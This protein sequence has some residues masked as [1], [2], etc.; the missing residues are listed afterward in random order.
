[1]A[2]SLVAEQ[3]RQEK[4]VNDAIVKKGQDEMQYLFDNHIL[5][6][7]QYY[8]IASKYGYG[9]PDVYAALKASIGTYINVR[10]GGSSGSSG[11][12]GRSGGS[13]RSGGASGAN[14]TVLKSLFGTAGIES[15]TDIVNYCDNH[16]IHLS[17]DNLNTL[18]KA[19]Y[20][21]QTGTGEY[22][23]MYDITEEQIAAASG[24]DKSNF[25]SNMAVIKQLVREE[26]VKYREAHNGQEPSLNWLIQAGV[27][28]VVT[29]EGGYSQAQM[30]AAGILRITVDNNGYAYVTDIY[31]NTY[32]IDKWDIERILTNETTLPAVV[33]AA[34]NSSADDSSSDDSSD[35]DG[36]TIDTLRN[37]ASEVGEA[38]SDAAEAAGES[39]TEHVENN[40][41]YVNGE[42]EDQSLGGGSYVY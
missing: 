14:I 30:R 31:H 3:R 4:E 23:P 19:A 21:Y 42:D 15:Y 40:V 35:D 25:E 17:Q 13:G 11:G 38:V 37:A 16:G 22:K 26:A 6:P 1:M 41:A 8:A 12:G 29:D 5:D 36:S 9:K 32:Y 18:Q 33:E 24:I 7:S 27:N 10:T 34:A 39:I 20:E 2:T 28:T